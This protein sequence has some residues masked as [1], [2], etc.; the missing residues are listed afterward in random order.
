MHVAF[1][2]AG[3]VESAVKAAAVAA[4]LADAP[5]FAPD[6]RTADPRHGDFQANGV[7][8]Y[9]KARRLNPRTVAEQLIAALP[10]SIRTMADATI[11]GPGFIN[12]SL[13]PAALH[14]WLRAFPTRD[15]LATGDDSTDGR[16]P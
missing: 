15:A 16:G 2:L 6:V 10:D 14:A 12:F 3:E 4:G 5:A 7:L 11:A 9:A 1:N 8:A 13:K